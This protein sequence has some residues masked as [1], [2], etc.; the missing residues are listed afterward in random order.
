[1]FL[2]K[3]K[4][5]GVRGSVPVS[6]R[7]T[8]RY[9]CNTPSLS[10]PFGKNKILILDAG[11]GIYALGKELAKKNVEIF[12]LFSHL[13]W[14]HVHG[15]PFFDPLY[16]SK[17]AITFL[18]G[19]GPLL[20]EV[21]ND[22]MDGKKF[23]VK[24]S[25]VLS[26]HR[27][28]AGDELAVLK[29]EGLRVEKIANNHPGGAFSYRIYS[30]KGSCV[31]ATDNELESSA[32]HVAFCKGADILIH[33]AQYIKKDMP[34]KAGW[35]HSTVSQVQDLAKAAK[36]KQLV[37]FHHDPARTDKEL[38]KIVIESKSWAKKNKLS[39]TCRAAK[40]GLELAF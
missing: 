32:S 19:F 15:L 20:S 34:A 4:L 26:K 27:V 33:D 28:M 23:P 1:M 3:I 40:E 16:E 21:L 22:L 6:A 10:I 8:I 12:I 36:I 14:D 7:D 35:G 30:E 37:Y 31:Y 24:F 18:S 25:K 38:D 5:W 17:R 13:H 2:M 11:T 39:T 29:K 9:G